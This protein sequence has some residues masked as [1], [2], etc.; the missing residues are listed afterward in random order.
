MAAPECMVTLASLLPGDAGV[1]ADVLGE[2]AFRRRLLDMGFTKGAL[3]KVIK[4][5]PF[6]D[7]IEYSI[8]GTHVTLRQQE[9]R[10]II[11]DHVE[12]RIRR[13]KRRLRR[14]DTSAGGP[15][16]GRGWRRRDR[17]E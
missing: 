17:S 14:R 5:A 7:P 6:R 15:R 2:G 16:R 9:A 10:Q 4:Q 13:A 12:C 1:I 3:V 11:V 8:G